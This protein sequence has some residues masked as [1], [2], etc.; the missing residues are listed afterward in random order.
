MFVKAGAVTLKSFTGY[1]DLATKRPVDEETIYHWASVTKTLTG[2]AVMQ[3]RDRGLLSLDDPIV[4]YLPELRQ[5]HN[6]YGSMS[7][8]TIRQLM[9]HSAGFRAS[10][11][12]WG[13][14]KEWEPF[15]PPRYEQLQAMLPYTELLFP[16]GS[17]YSYSNPGIVFLGRTIELLTNEDY[18]VYVDKNVLRPLGMHRS[19]FD[20]TPY[21][22]LPHRS[23]SYFFDGQSY[24]EARFD[25]D[26]GVTVSNGGLNGPLGDMALYLGFL[27]GD[28]PIRAT[29]DSVLKR[30]S[31]EEMWQPVV[32]VAQEEDARVAMGLTYFLERRAGL[33]LVA[34]SG[35]QNGFLSHFFV[36]VP[37]RVAYIVAYNTQAGGDEP[38]DA[39]P[40]GASTRQLDAELRDHLLE[41][42]F[43]RLAERR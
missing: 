36:N 40:T 14:D 8:V 41:R 28:R 33:D 43:P 2:V 1:Q 4:K 6:P 26:T 29:Y 19:F 22:L 12:P 18:E 39:T 15:E 17:K 37:S 16:P 5:V 23:H 3:L 30:S 31:L 24:R 11:W 42:L 25:F 35:S 13:T 7:D 10:T 9:S 20:R 38:G 27:A 32:A 34:H 21:Y